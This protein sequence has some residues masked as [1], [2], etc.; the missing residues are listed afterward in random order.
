MV[1]ALE[2]AGQRFG[3]LIAVSRAANATRGTAMWHCLCDCGG[4][5]IVFAS[6][7][8]RGVTTSCGCFMREFRESGATGRTHGKSK[9]T[10]YNTWRHMRARCSKPTHEAYANYGGRGIAVC[11]RWSSFE[12][13]YT[14]MGECPPG[15]SLDRIDVN[16]DYS[17][18]NCRWAT[19]V[20]QARNMRS[21]KVLAF[22]GESK[23]LSEWCESLALCYRTVNTRL[24][25]GWS[26]E[27][28]LTT[29][30][31]RFGG[32]V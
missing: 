10:T 8:S 3:R 20:I 7:L 22:N 13:F 16:G 17:P 32:R 12:N 4:R 11:A 5:S 14:D 26:V 29:K 23:C 27:R 15:A 18:D 9:A 6:N 25:R 2:L 30:T 1:K 21:N 24:L 28:A 31:G 19:P